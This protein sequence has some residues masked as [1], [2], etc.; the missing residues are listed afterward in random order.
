IVKRHTLLLHTSLKVERARFP[1]VTADFAA[2]SVDT[3][4]H[5]S[6]RLSWGNYASANSDEECQV[7]RLMKE[8]NVMSS[9]V[10]GSSASRFAMRNEICGLMMDKG[11]PTFCIT[12]NP[13]NIF[14]PIVKFLAGG[15]IDVDNLLPGDVPEYWEQTL[16][17]S[18]NPLVAA[19]FFNIY[20]CAF[21]LTLLAFNP[22]QR[23]MEGGILGVV[24][25]YYGCVKA[26]SCGTL[27]CHMMVWVEGGAQTRSRRR[28]CGNTTL[29]SRR[30]S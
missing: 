11:L 24:K 22:K 28:S 18:K 19:Q 13:A 15:E 14:N 6:E 5:V 30:G 16:L 8:V 20:M 17:I 7:L 21:I 23:N 4:H 10:P 29:S 1:V 26:Q 9:H 12:M 25:A 2:V 3:V 27:H